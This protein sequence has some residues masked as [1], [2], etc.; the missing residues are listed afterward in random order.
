MSQKRTKINFDFDTFYDTLLPVLN[1]RKLAKRIYVSNTNVFE[2][3][4]PTVARLF[5]KHLIDGYT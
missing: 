1:A 5:K 4:L 2:T 3:G